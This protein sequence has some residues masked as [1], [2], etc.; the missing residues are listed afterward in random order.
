MLKKR[1]AEGYI[2]HYMDKY[3]DPANPP[4]WMCFELLS[5]GNLS[6]FIKN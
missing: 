4:A 3:K 2:K 5:I 6:F 1:K